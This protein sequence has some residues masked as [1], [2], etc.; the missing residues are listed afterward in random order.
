MDQGFILLFLNHI[1]NKTFEIIWIIIVSDM[2]IYYFIRP[3]KKRVT[4]FY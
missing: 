3:I 4:V 2:V 1:N